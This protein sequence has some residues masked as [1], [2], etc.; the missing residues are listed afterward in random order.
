VL[1]SWLNNVAALVGI[2]TGLPIIFGSTISWLGR[3]VKPPPKSFHV[4]DDPDFL[5][6]NKKLKDQ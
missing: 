2:V 4:S 5:R 1:P 3:G 6:L